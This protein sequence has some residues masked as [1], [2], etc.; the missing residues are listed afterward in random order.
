MGLNIHSVMRVIVLLSKLSPHSCFKSNLNFIMF[1]SIF[2]T[3]MLQKFQNLIY[4]LHQTRSKNKD[5][6]NEEDR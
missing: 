3:I 4:Q 6:K 2:F 5:E 1:H